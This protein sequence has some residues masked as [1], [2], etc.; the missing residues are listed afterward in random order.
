MSRG[1]GG[2]CPAEG[3]EEVAR[4]PAR[5]GLGDGDG[6]AEPEPEPVSGTGKRGR[7]GW[8]RGQR[9]KG[10]GPQGAA[11]LGGGWRLWEV[12]GEIWMETLIARVC[13]SLS[14]YIYIYSAWTHMSAGLT[15][16][17]VW[18]SF[19]HTRV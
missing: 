12:G 4:G 9:G 6:G 7:S 3:T 2:L 18:I 17:R 19:F 13:V 14:L 15:G 1:G 11:V 5:I 10:G 8:K 16:L